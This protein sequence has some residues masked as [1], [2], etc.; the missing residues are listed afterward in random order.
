MSQNENELL[1][2]DADGIKEYDNALPRWWLYGFYGTIVM[3]VLYMI[4]WHV[5]TEPVIGA[6]DQYVEYNQELEH[7]KLA[8]G[9]APRKNLD[10]LVVL[11]D[12]PSLLRGKEIFEGT[13]NLC[14]TCHRTDLGGQVGPN[15]T[16]D[17]WL[18]GCSVKDIITSITT[19]FPAEGM[20]PYGST[21]KLS[22]DDLLKVA[23]YIVSKLGSNPV[24]PKPINPERD[25]Q[26]AS[27]PEQPL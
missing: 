2:H 13:D 23:S 6:K 5:L 15:L 26:C 3:A 12:A 8:A 1:D 18:H 20:L 10:N 4:N 25:V 24:D 7:W 22:D 14:A 17:L 11:E 9:K 21:N 16:D 27:K 19:G